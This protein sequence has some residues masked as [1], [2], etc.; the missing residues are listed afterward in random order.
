[1]VYLETL[2]YEVLYEIFKYLN[3]CDLLK[4]VSIVPELE[5]FCREK[6]FKK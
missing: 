6:K 4:V 3:T 2:P 1:M 5:Y